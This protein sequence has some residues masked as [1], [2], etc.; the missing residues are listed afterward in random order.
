MSKEND[1][2]AIIER[3]KIATRCKGYQEMAA[4]L[5]LKISWLKFSRKEGKLHPEIKDALIKMGID[6]W[7][8]EFG[9]G[10]RELPAG[11]EAGHVCSGDEIPAWLN[12]V[13]A[14]AI[15]E[16]HAATPTDDK[17]DH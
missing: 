4:G 17:K 13:F 1:G 14:E 2:D 5:K 3:L 12:P 9:A 8:V 11:I 6:P 15:E 10:R 16:F 7:W